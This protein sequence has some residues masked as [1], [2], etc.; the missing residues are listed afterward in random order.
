[1]ADNDK[2]TSLLHVKMFY[3]EGRKSVLTKPS[4][5]FDTRHKGHYGLSVKLNDNV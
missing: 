5:M 4:L 1:M 3:S 2:H